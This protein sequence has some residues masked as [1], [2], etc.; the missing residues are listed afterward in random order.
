[1]MEPRTKK[2]VLATTICLSSVATLALGLWVIHGLVH[3]P[4]STESSITI[5]GA[6]KKTLNVSIED[7]Y[8]G[9][10]KTYTV[11][12]LGREAYAYSLSLDFTEKGGSLSKWLTLYLKAGDYE[13][14]MSLK[15]AFSLDAPISLGK[16]VTKITMTYKMGEETGDAAQGQSVDFDV[17]LSAEK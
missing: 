16:N 11:N 13:G 12:V 9:D 14:E 2:K 4:L 17:L 3:K 7:I 6:T 10:E 1:M 5:N 15:D 8:P